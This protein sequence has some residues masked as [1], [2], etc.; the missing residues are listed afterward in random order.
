M[1]TSVTFFPSLSARQVAAEP[2][3]TLK[4]RFAEQNPRLNDSPVSL[5]ARPRLKK[6]VEVGTGHIRKVFSTPGVFNDDLFVVSGLKLYRGGYG[7]TFSDKGTISTQLTGGVS[8]CAVAPIGTTPAFLWIAEGGILWVY[9]DN[10]QAMGH[11]EV[12]GTLANNDTFVIGGVYYKLTTGSVDTGTPNGSSGTPYLVNK[13]LSNGDAITNLYNAINATG[14]AGTDYSTN[15]VDPHATVFA[16]SSS[17][18]DLYVYAIE[19][20]TAGNSIAVS[21][22]SANAA[23]TAATLAGGGSEQ[24]RQVQV[25]GDVGAISVAQINSYVIVVPIQTTDLKG[26]FFWVNPGETKIDPTDFATAERSPDGINQVV[27]FGEMFW[28]MGQNTTEP[29]ITT[30]DA[31]APMERFKGVLY[32]RGS[33]EGAAIQVKDSLVTIDEDGGVWVISGGSNR[34]STPDIEEKIRRAIQKAALIASF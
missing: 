17:S 5:I 32:D 7:G 24:L 33:W 16:G 27:V 26:Q 4:N 18:T 21:E 12:T 22:T 6:F 19:Y 34:V 29:W 15:I 9:T 3:I 8:M 10:G 13:G 20:G 14:V 30:G 2:V 28:L 1:V 31:T 11:L 23:W 25:P